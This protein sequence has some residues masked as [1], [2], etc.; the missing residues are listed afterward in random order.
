MRRFIPTQPHSLTAIA[1]LAIL[2]LVRTFLLNATEIADSVTL[3]LF[4]G[5]YWVAS[6]AV[7]GWWIYLDR[8]RTS[9]SPFALAPALAAIFWPVGIPAYLLGTRKASGIS[10]ILVAGIFLTGFALVGGLLGRL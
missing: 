2:I 10:K 9:K 3:P 8:S 4:E 6:F 7:C 5:I 1:L